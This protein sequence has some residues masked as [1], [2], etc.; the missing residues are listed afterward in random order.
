ML[1]FLKASGLLEEVGRNVY[2]ATGAGLAW[3]RSGDEV[4]F[5][6]ILHANMKFV[7]EMIACARRRRVR[8]DLYAIA[9]GY[10]LN[11]EKARWNCRLPD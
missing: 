5:I 7:G 3:L 1:P 2:C 11:T 4:D 10:G 9:K 6:R 8:N